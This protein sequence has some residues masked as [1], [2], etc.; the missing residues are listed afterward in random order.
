MDKQTTAVIQIRNWIRTNGKM[1]E[2]GKQITYSCNELD[3]IIEQKLKVE[4]DIIIN[5]FKHA[6]ALHA[7]GDDTRAVHYF[8]KY[9]T[10]K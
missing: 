9:F 5:T 2:D 3:D 4:L 8:H 7:V 10:Q 1:S 6:Q